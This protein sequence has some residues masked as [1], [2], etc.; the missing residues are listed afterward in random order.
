MATTAGGT[1]YAASSEA[2]SGYPAISLNLANQIES[3]L[4][5]K[6]DNSPTVNAQTGTTYT[7]A[8][9]DLGKTITCSNASAVTVTVNT[10]LSSLATGSIIRIVNVGAGLVTVVAS[11]T[12]IAGSPLT[13]AQNKGASL[14]KTGTNAYVMLPF[15][16]ADRAT[17]SATTGSPTVTTV[18]GKT[19]IKWTGSGSITVSAAG[20]VSALIIGAGGGGASGGGGGGGGAGGVFG[21]TGN[22]VDIYLPVGTHTVTI[23]AGGSASAAGS[24][25][26]VSGFVALGGGGG[27][28]GSGA[29]GGGNGG[30]AIYGKQG[31]GGGASN[32]GGGGASQA[33]TGSGGKGGDGV[34]DSI[35]GTPTTRA[36]GGG[37]YS[38]GAGGAGGG[39][40]GHATATNPGTANTGGGGGASGNAGGAGG[41][42]IVILLIG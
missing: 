32:G 30:T 10:G 34:S 11:G 37:G 8:T 1:Y 33:G 14:L 38:S 26:L 18:S 27:T 16:G 31:Y 13:I 12:T 28:A 22:A 3:R 40:A 20:F 9:T 19:C 5:A 17:Y 35:D 24:A 29:S 21:N 39:G 15:S 23:G 41:S 36:G 25:S 6:A 42:G 7:V 4:A 2:V